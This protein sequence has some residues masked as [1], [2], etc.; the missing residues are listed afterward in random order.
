[1]RGLDSSQERLVCRVCGGHTVCL[2]PV[3]GSYSRRDYELRRCDECRYAYIAEPWTEFARIYDDAYYA[4]MGADPLVDYQFELEEPDATIRVYEWRGIVRLVETLLGGLDGIRW[5]DFGAGNGGLVRY[6]S[7]HT[8]ASAVGFEEGAIA[9]R[10]RDLGIPIKP[11]LE[12]E[13]PFSY[14][15]V[16]AIEV[17]EHAIDPLA[18]LRRIRKMLRPGGVLLLT[19]GNAAPFASRLTRWPYVIPEI[20]VS[21]FEPATLVHALR[22]CGFRPARMPARDGFDDVM[23]FKV[24]KNLRLRRRTVLTDAIPAHPVAILADAKTRLGAHPIGWAI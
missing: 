19:T 18:E 11:S 3:H 4:G 6:V 13:D 2:G 12:S 5:L 9:G 1:M 24:L 7:H 23:K 21:F 17:L 14:D 8:T 15:V 22:S 10:A 16:T 20:H